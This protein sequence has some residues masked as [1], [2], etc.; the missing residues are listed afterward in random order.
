MARN[1][2]N[3]KYVQLLLDPSRFMLIEQIAKD[4][5]LKP[6][7]LIRQAIYDWLGLMMPKEV[8]LAAEKLDEARWQQSVQNRIQGRNKRSTKICR[9]ES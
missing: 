4:K 8:I 5:G 3:K 2:G 6:N 1:H 7:A 9:G